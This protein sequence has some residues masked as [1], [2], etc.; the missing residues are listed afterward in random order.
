MPGKKK[1]SCILNFKER[2]DIFV[3]TVLAD[4]LDRITPS[5]SYKTPASFNCRQ[6][7]AA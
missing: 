3:H 4:T 2:H 5:C 7:P 6:K 1:L